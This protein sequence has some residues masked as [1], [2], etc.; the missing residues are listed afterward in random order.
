[1]CVN[2]ENPELNTNKTTVFSPDTRVQITCGLS[3]VVI[4]T[5]QATGKTRV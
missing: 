5:C 2:E 3:F 4:S 1:M